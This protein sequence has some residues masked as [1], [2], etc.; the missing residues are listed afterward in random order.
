F[1]GTAS[2]SPAARILAA[3]DVYHAMTEPRPHRAALS[4]ERAA[5]ELQGEVQTGRLDRDSVDAVLGAAGHRVARRSEHAAG[6]TAREVEV[7]RLVAR[8]MS[9]REVTQRLV[10]SP[11]TAD[12]H[13]QSIYSKAGVTSR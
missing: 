6:L 2:L 4:P 5:T 7:L 8:G 1:R 3:A 12:H 13:V 9:T 11:K 10:I